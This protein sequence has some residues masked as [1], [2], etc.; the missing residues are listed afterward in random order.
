MFSDSE[1]AIAKIGAYKGSCKQLNASKCLSQTLIH[2]YFA[3]FEGEVCNIVLLYRHIKDGGNLILW[4]C[5]GNLFETNYF[6]NA[7]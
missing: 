3:L 1:M 6:R 7:V 5:S 4:E 2:N